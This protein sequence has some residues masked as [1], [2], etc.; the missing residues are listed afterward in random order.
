MNPSTKSNVILWA[1]IILIIANVVLL[2]AFFLT[3]MH[4]DPHSNQNP[5]GFIEKELGF[6]EKQKDEFNALHVAHH[7]ETEELRRNIN[8]EEDSLF[9]LLKGTAPLENNK[10]SL[11]RE[12]G[13]NKSQI[14]SLTFEH[15]KK[16]R[17]LCNP[18]QQ[19]KFDEIIRD[20]VK[21][22]APPP[23]PM[24]PRD[25]HREA[26]VPPAP[27]IPPPPPPIK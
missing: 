25:E 13:I 8:E 10:T 4:H 7:Q 5:A 2:S 11:I 9:S 16:L 19:K 24:P 18:Q 3:R 12:L 22:I 14:D 1:V 21:S 20:V 6:D 23:P 15:F 17:A 26:P 27:P